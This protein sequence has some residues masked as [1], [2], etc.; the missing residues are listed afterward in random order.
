MSDRWLRLNTTWSH[1]WVA[2]LGPTA[3]LAWIELMCHVKAHGHDGR[4]RAMSQSIFG[5]M[6]GIA[7]EDVGEMLR[8]AVAAGALEDTGGEWFIVNWMK[9][10]GDFGSAARSRRYRN[11]KKEGVT[12]DTRDATPTETVT[13][14]GTHSPHGPPA[15]ERVRRGGRRAGA[16]AYTAEFERVWEILPPR[17][18]GDSKPEAFQQWQARIGEG[19][20]PAELEAGAEAYGRYIEATGKMGTEFVLQGKTFFGLRKRGWEQRW[21][22]PFN[23]SPK[24]SV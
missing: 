12:G 14:T 3:R 16:P 10:Q 4:V 8:G 1:G 23:R 19:V 5:R 21:A 11:K 17:A 7:A 13:E 20:S 24:P 18:G 2:A 6:Y 15:G 9:Y 22:A